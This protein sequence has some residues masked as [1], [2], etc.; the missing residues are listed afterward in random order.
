MSHRK[1]IPKLKRSESLSRL[2][3][4]EM[5]LKSI[6]HC[7]KLHKADLENEDIAETI[8]KCSERISSLICL[9]FK[10]TTT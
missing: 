5:I 8:L 1:T 7:S 4:R 10:K 6:Q 2:H 3:L 9:G